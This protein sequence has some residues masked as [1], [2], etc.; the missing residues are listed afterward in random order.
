VFR[1]DPDEI[2]HDVRP[3]LDD[4]KGYGIGITT[5]GSVLLATSEGVVRSADRGATWTTTA[6]GLASR[7]VYAFACDGSAV[8]AGTGA[9]VH[10]S[11]DDGSSWER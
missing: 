2:W 7:T 6:T 8:F 10:R 5:A 11:I 9:G 1:L 3:G 4:A